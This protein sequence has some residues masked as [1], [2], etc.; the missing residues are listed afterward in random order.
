MTFIDKIFILIN[1]LL[2]STLNSSGQ[3]HVSYH[4]DSTQ[5]DLTDFIKQGILEDNRQFT[6]GPTRCPNTSSSCSY[7]SIIDLDD[8]TVLHE[9]YLERFITPQVSNPMY[10]DNGSLFIT[11]R[12][13]TD[14]ESVISILELDKQDLSFIREKKIQ[15]DT[16]GSSVSQ[17]LTKVLNAIILVGWSLYPDQ[18][19]AHDFILW[20]DSN[21]LDTIR[22]QTLPFEG[23]S[24]IPHF[25]FSNPGDQEVTVYF[26]LMNG[27]LLDNGIEVNSRGFARF[28]NKGK[29]TFIGL[30]SI[31]ISSTHG[32]FHA[33]L[34]HSN[35]NHI[36]HQRYVDDNVFGVANFSN[37]EI[38][39]RDS[40]GTLLWRFDNP[41]YS[42][43]GTKYII[44]INEDQNGNILCCGYVDWRYDLGPG[45]FE[46][47]YEN[48]NDPIIDS[49]AIVLDTYGDK[50]S[51]PYIFLLDGETGELIW[52][53][54]I[55]DQNSDG[56]AYSLSDFQQKNNGDY[57]GVGIYQFENSV[58]DNW[59][60]RLP[61]NFSLGN[62]SNSGFEYDLTLTS[63]EEHDNL[64]EENQF[65]I[66]PNPASNI[67]NFNTNIQGSFSYQIINKVGSIVQKGA[68]SDHQ[69]SIENLLPGLYFLELK[70]EQN[71]KIDQA[72]FFKY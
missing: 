47:E 3:N 22:S 4:W 43:V 8:N 67:I 33:A 62:G 40:L 57:V 18:N 38:L 2:F 65:R 23:K 37:F 61:E 41:G 42:K 59:L 7:V 54:S 14:D 52:Q 5:N 17:G 13:A 56:N 26:S 1:I 27:L 69:I 30:D 32:L 35:G 51:A 53:Y 48:A 55:I 31:D 70:N 24:T 20:L 45:V 16:N 68:L 11:G 44:S 49:I 60:L 6:F 50:Y 63:T 66:Y 15:L 34:L 39:C 58:V 28:N 36:Y 46:F 21:T 12:D 10:L 29:N 9:K 25:I 72:K 71:E 19:Y 64:T